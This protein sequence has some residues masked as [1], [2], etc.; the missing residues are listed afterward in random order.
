MW[1][2]GWFVIHRAHGIIVV[3]VVVLDIDEVGS[4]AD[5]AD[6]PVFQSQFAHLAR[7]LFLEFGY[8]CQRVA[9]RRRPVQL[10]IIRRPG[11]LPRYD[12]FGHI[13]QAL[14]G[15][16]LL[17][18]IGDLILGEV[19]DGLNEGLEGGVAG[20]EIVNVLLVDALTAMV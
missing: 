16:N 8:R 3:G 1:Q 11:I 20:L 10:F 19:E 18:Q 12:R 2:Q 6:R 9:V 15:S 7:Q 17:D 4:A 5:D 14:T 13:V